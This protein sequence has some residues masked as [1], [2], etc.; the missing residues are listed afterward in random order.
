[1]TFLPKGYE[2]PA[3]NSNYFKFEEGDNKFRIMSS[4]I[5]G[6]LD[7]DDKKPVR[8]KEK[9]T[10]LFNSE[11]QAKHFWAFIVWD[12]KE[13]KL[14]IMEIT[15]ATI[16]DSILGLHNDEGWG[17]PTE[18][19]ITILRKGKDIETKYTVIPKPPTP[20]TDEMTATL[21]ES[22][23]NLNAL[24]SGGDPFAKE[25]P[26]NNEAQNNKKPH[27]EDIEVENIPF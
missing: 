21:K 24:F 19:D 9:P 5:V 22:N 8:T 25:T 12:Y 2:K 14:K 27:T 7:W 10:T 20:L 16:Q 26:H 18:Y 23:I 13:S 11:K 15:Q 3:G 17:S 4:A 6:F 1:M